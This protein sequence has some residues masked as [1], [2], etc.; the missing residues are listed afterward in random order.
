MKSV[1]TG[2]EGSKSGHPSQAAHPDNAVRV[3]PMVNIAPLLTEMG[4]DPERV[5]T[6]AGLQLHLF[7]KPDNRVTYLAADRLFAECVKSTNCDYFGLLAGQRGQ[8]HDLGLAGFLVNA[9]PNAGSALTA[10]IQYF[11]LHDEG[12]SLQLL[13]DPKYSTFKF[14]IHQTGMS[15]IEQVWDFCA[16]I[17]CNIMRTICDSD[18]AEAEFRIPR[19]TP[20]DTTPYRRCF[21]A[22]IRFNEPECAVIFP[23][24]WLE[25]PVTSGDTRMFRHLQAEAEIQHKLHHHDLVESLPSAITRSLLVK[26]FSAADIAALLGLQERTFHRRLQAKGTTFRA[27][28]DS[29]R[30]NLADKLLRGT[31]MSVGEIASCLGY[32]DSAGFIKAF[33]RW[34]GD[35]PNK[36]RKKNRN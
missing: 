12:G 22:A 9:A 21:H 36:W 20:A 7:A 1:R 8:P 29:A 6:R 33:H 10:L 30:K 35:S 31:N 15:A 32:S 16:A 19:R 18:C 3:G 24:K 25:K 14:Q 11:D 2:A 13:R 4:E 34:V 17:M 28:M 26:R 27:E 5:F 23:T